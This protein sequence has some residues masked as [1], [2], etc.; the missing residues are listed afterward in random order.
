MIYTLLQAVQLILSS[1]DSDEVNS[2]S[3]TSEAYQIAL[4]AQSVFYD[5]CVDLNLPS[6]HTIFQ[7]LASGDSTKPTIM[8]IP[9][10][11]IRNM[12]WIQYDNIDP[13]VGDTT[14]NWV[15]MYELEF[16]DFIERQNGFRNDT[17]GSILQYSFTGINGTFNTNARKDTF[18][19]YWCTFDDNTVL[20]DN[21]RAD[22]ETTLEQ[23]KTMCS[24][25]IYQ[26]FL[27][28][29]NFVPQLEPQQFS[30]WINKIKSRAWQELKQ[31]PNQEAMA[32]ARRQKVVQQNRKRNINQIPAVF[33]VARYGRNSM[34]GTLGSILEKY[35]RN[36]I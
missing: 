5:I 34:Y 1:L 27:L 35:G 14:S 9:S 4:M 21:Y 26:T 20:I 31:M 28:Q 29:D 23:S 18:P 17:T 30:Y 10:L 32:E 33:R 16:E 7:L 25:Y 3:D 22:I 12:E 2:I 24:G 6:Q 8:K 13:T 19:L 15:P 11:N 36:T